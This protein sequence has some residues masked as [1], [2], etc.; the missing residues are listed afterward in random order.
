MTRHSPEYKQWK[1]AAKNEEEEK[2]LRRQGEA[3]ASAMQAKFESALQAV[4]PP[5]STRA[6]PPEQPEVPA[7][8]GAV[9]PAASGAASGG[10]DAGGD[11]LSA[12]QLRWL[13]AEFS[14][15]V[16]F[17]KGARADVVKALVGSMGNRKN[18]QAIADFYARYG[19][20]ISV[21][22]PKDAR[23]NTLFDIAKKH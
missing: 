7:D 17:K 22:R 9:V 3:L 10:S 14:H 5:P 18:V 2:R 16:N 15:E 23:A 13:S 20:G 8:G 11:A 19:K 6:A 21:P 12:V 4:M 1:E